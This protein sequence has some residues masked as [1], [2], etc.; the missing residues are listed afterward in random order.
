MYKFRA[1]NSFNYLVGYFLKLINVCVNEHSVDLAF[2]D[3]SSSNAAESDESFDSYAAYSS[4]QSSETPFTYDK[5]Y[6]YLWLIFAKKHMDTF[7][8]DNESTSD[9]KL[10]S[11][12]NLFLDFLYICLYN[13]V[14]LKQRNMIMFQLSLYSNSHEETN[15]DLKSVGFN[16]LLAFICLKTYL[17][18]KL[19]FDGDKMSI[20][21]A[22]VN[23]YIFNSSFILNGNG[24]T[25]ISDLLTSYFNSDLLLKDPNDSDSK[26][27]VQAMGQHTKEKLNECEQLAKANEKI[28]LP[29]GT[30]FRISSVSQAFMFKFEQAVNFKSLTLDNSY[31]IQV[32]YLNL[33]LRVR[34]LLYLLSLLKQEVH[35][36]LYLYK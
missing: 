3:E 19:S 1:D 17:S 35:L 34:H 5:D 20:V 33:S 27:V 23:D 24:Q 36:I 16:Q 12:Q 30:K 25:N 32:S 31:A 21:N 9:K 22:F 7:T 2:V 18:L 4:G 15:V 28:K 14:N 29:N 13:L 10:T 11:A 8:F 26:S 6:L